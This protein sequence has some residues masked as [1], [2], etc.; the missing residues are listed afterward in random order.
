MIEYCIDNVDAATHSQL[1]KLSGVQATPCL[2]HCGLCFESQ[3]V[4]INGEFRAVEPD[5]D[6]FAINRE[7]KR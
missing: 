7:K 4:V 5:E 3:F 1:S 6:V 2:G